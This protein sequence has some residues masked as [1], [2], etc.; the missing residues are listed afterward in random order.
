MESPEISVIVPVY[1]VE[2]Y[3]RRCLDSIIGQTYQNLE[4]ILVDDGS[5]DRCGEI[6]EEYAARDARVQVLH[7]PNGGVS[8]ARNAGLAV[9]TGK[10]IGLV[11]AD[12]WIEP[13]MYEYLLDLALKYQADMVQC[14]FFF[15]Q[16]GRREARFVLNELVILHKRVS[17]LTL[18]QLKLL[19]NSICTK[20]YRAEVQSGLNF[21]LSYPIGEDLLFQLHALVQMDCI[22]FAPLAKYHYV[23]R[24]SS[25]C[26]APPTPERL[27]SYR[28][29]LETAKEMF[30]PYRPIYR[31][32]HEELLRNSL[33]MCSKIIRYRL[34]WTA[35][36]ELELRREI[37]QN[38]KYIMI[39]RS[40]LW[41]EKL[42]FTVIAICW[43][44]Y[45]VGLP[46]WKKIF[47]F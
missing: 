28:Y 21:D 33:D 7:K 42:K 5:P 38:L 29:M 44:L 26:N 24:D 23:Q 27:V 12:D 34:D 41:K 47:T 46:I 10:W 22:V 31:F 17:E 8:F 6:C 35:A 18:E 11:D 14:G 39:S 2:P 45:R 20:L 9:A 1:K 16:A 25:A 40:F 30:G 36:L 13:D 15:E 37:R 3:L 4:I 19:S 43:P 32:L